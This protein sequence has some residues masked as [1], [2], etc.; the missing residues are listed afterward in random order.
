MD[1][2][3]LQKKFHTLL[4]VVPMN[5]SDLARF[6]NFDPSYISR[7]RNGQRQPANPTEF[8]RKVSAFVARHFQTAE[9][10]AIISSLTNCPVEELS[11]YTDFQDRL[12]NWLLSG[13]GDVKDSMTVFLEKLDEFNLDEYI[14]SIHFNELKVPS[15]PFQIPVAKTYWGI[16]EMMESE[17]DFL[18]ATVL[19]KSTAPVIMYSDMPMKEMAKDPEFPKKWMF[20]MALMLKKGLHLYQIHNL[21]R[22]FDEMMLGLESWIPMYMTGLISPYY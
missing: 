21:D 5:I 6:L 9:Q 2:A 1:I 7:I 10:K 13:A 17:L 8:A 12:T 18:K 4:T 19:S 22:S 3:H 15:V 16:K 20:G 11:N 14:H